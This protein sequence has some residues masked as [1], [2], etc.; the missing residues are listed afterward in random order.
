[1]KKYQKWIPHFK[2]CIG[3]DGELDEILSEEGKSALKKLMNDTLS[4][5]KGTAD[6]I[7]RAFSNAGFDDIEQLLS[8]WTDD[9]M[10]QIVGAV[11]FSLIKEDNKHGFKSYGWSGSEKIIVFKNVEFTD[12]IQLMWAVNVV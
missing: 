6:E 1:M 7:R 5:E 4:D 12:V 11:E 8:Y 9:A 10:S 3:E 2:W